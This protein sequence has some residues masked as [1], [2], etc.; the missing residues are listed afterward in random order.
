MQE[1]S[2]PRETLSRIGQLPDHEID[3]GA[4]AL[5]LAAHQRLGAQTAPYAAH[6]SELAK[7]VSDDAQAADSAE[8]RAALLGSVLAG[9]FRYAGDERDYDNLDNANLMAVIDR[10]RGLPVS[11][12]ILYIHV[13]RAQGW[14]I[15]GLTFP[16]HFLLRIEG[17][18]GGRAV[19]DPFHGARI[20][21]ASGM[22][23][24]LK[25]V[26]GIGAELEPSLYEPV[27]NRDILVR[28]QNNLKL[29]LLTHGQIA[30][31]L[32]IVEAMLLV[33]PHQV[34]LWREAGMMQ[35]RLGNL[36]AAIAA[37]EHFVA[38]APNSQ[39]R[40]RATALLQELRGRLH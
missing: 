22:R 19:F 27:G 24:L 5:A 25:V 1:T 20:L 35:L 3:L 32:E 37:L 31:A 6:L 2:T 8:A 23:E 33:A 7:A 40:H 36:G 17:A 39:T 13:A 28:L 15:A 29:R 9:R 38:Q 4:A 11:L 26:A 18:D 16:A 30:Q 10:R 14:P 21:D 12:G 34:M